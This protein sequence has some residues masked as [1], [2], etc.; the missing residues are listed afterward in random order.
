MKGIEK[1]NVNCTAALAVECLTHS[2]KS[3]QFQDRRLSL[4]NNR[5]VLMTGI[6]DLFDLFLSDGAVPCSQISL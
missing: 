4:E 6:S 3:V 2:S 5:L 1:A